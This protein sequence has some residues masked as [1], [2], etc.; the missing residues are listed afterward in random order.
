MKPSTPVE[1]RVLGRMPEL[2]LALI[3]PAAACAVLAQAPLVAILALAVATAWALL[4]VPLAFACLIV[5][6]MRNPVRARTR[7]AR[8]AG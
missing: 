2:I 5:T 8:G 7:R 3:V 4:L 6:A 1:E